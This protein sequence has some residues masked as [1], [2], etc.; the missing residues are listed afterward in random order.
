MNDPNPAAIC[1]VGPSL[2]P[3][4]SY[5]IGHFDAFLI[6]VSTVLG[7]LVSGFLVYRFAPEAEGH[8]T[9]AAIWAKERV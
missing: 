9:D 5:S 2:P 4:P 8:G 6:P 1:A 3:L 7:G